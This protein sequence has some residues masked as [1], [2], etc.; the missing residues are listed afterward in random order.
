MCVCVAAKPLLCINSFGR[1]GGVWPGSHG[2]RP[3]RPGFSAR[4]VS[5]MFVAAPNRKRTE[6][7]KRKREQ[8]TETGDRCD[9]KEQYAIYHF[10][11]EVS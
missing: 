10:H 7:Q 8:E 4:L 9:L 11:R 5:V 1:N 6:P 3:S 2:D